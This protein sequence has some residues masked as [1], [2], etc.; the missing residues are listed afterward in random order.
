MKKVLLAIAAVATITSCSQNEEFENPPQKAEIGFNSAAVT[1]ATAMVTADFK[2][3]QVYGYAHSNAFSEQTEGTSLVDGT[4]HYDAEKWTETSGDK[5]YWPVEGNVT[6]FAYSPI[7]ETGTTF[8]APVGGKGFPTIDYKV[9]D[10]IASQSDFLVAQ[11]TGNVT[12]NKEGISLG[13]KHV[14][15]QIAFKLKGSKTAVNYS[16]TKLVL[17]SIKDSGTYN[18]GTSKWTLKEDAASQNYEID[19]SSTPV[20]FSGEATTSVSL[21]GNDKI[22]ML[23]PQELGVNDATVEVTYTATQNGITLSNGNSAKVVKIPAVTW[24]AGQRITYTIALTPGDEMNIS[25]TVDDESWTDKDQGEI[26]Q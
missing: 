26:S 16:V 5:F 18:W 23:I 13:F 17:K 1:R 6:F 21:T 11:E 19:M 7:S 22:L 10:A 2:D 3:F 15:T 20:T 24:E 25:G 12:S 4:F 8:V 9:N 14:L